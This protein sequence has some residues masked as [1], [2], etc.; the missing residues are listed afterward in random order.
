MG[1]IGEVPALTALERIGPKGY[2]RY[3]FPFRLA[4]D[5]Q[6]DEVARVLRTGYQA[7]EQRL[8]VVGCE[9]IPDEDVK[10]GGVVKLQ[11]LTDPNVG[12]VAVKDLRETY[13][14]SYADLKARGFPVAEFDGEELCRRSVWPSAGERLPTSLVQ[15]N[16]IEGGLI[17]TWCIMHLVGDGT[18]F[19]TWTKIWAEECRRAQGI[20]IHELA[21]LPPAIWTDRELVM[22]PSGRNTGLP[23][24]HPEYTILPFTPPGAP[25]KMLSPNHCAQVFYFSPQALVALKAEASPA[26]ATQPSDQEW[27]STNDALS[28]LLW[29]TV[30]NVQSPLATLEGDPTSVFN[31]AIDGRRRT[32][33]PVHPETLGCFLGYIAVTMSIRRMLG[34]LSLADLAILIRQAIQRADGQYVDDVAMLAE[35]LEDV[36]RLVP[37]AFLDVPGYNCVLTSWTG[38]S[39]YDVEWGAMLGKIEAVRVPAIGVINGCQVVFPP[40]PDGGIEIL[41]GVENS[42]VDRLLA[43]PLWTKY[44]V[45]R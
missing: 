14:S 18:S 21:D 43:D 3:V 22:K 44:A 27:I 25:P 4:D 10:Q 41:V 24:N 20:P 12:G 16:F 11:R 15:L 37:T 28:A 32:S 26:H 39:M 30:M 17:L 5:Y 23:E 33:P 42:C 35:K 31:V 19:Y 40:L 13:P 9:L 2:L 6:I 45:A 1:S 38:F 34:E 7:L 8:P 36:N 29:R